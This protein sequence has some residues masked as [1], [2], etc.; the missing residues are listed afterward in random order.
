M[1]FLKR[2]L[3]SI[4]S[5]SDSRELSKAKKALS[6]ALAA[7]RSLSSD[8]SRVS[9]DLAASRDGADFERAE[10]TKANKELES[11]LAAVLEKNRAL[12]EEKEVLELKL[13]EA[14]ATL[15]LNDT[16]KRLMA[17]LLETL[18][19]RVQTTISSLADS[20]GAHQRSERDSDGITGA[21]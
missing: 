13:A 11:R 16:E 19:Q 7:N 9:D 8:F 15:A 21:R 14:R 1:R 10:F 2:L 17:D 12:R 20:Y 3:F 5:Y 18:R 6:S 4:C